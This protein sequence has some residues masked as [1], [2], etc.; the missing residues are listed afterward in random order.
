MFDNTDL[1][2][3]N[4][5]FFGIR[6]DAP[7]IERYRWSARRNRELGSLV[8]DLLLMRQYLKTKSP[9]IDDEMRVGIRYLIDELRLVIA[10]IPATDE[11]ELTMKIAALT[12]PAP[13]VATNGS[14][15]TMVVAAV[16][17]DIFAVKPEFVPPW[18]SAWL[19]A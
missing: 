9:T 4:D 15:E 18:M 16:R 12:K 19:E 13:L 17:A 10:T 3:G 11:Q 5:P 7:T 8:C 14:F 2:D 1:R 6:L